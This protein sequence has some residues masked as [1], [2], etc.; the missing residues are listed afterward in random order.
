MYTQAGFNKHCG[1]NKL[2]FDSN[3]WSKSDKVR[4]ATRQDG[5]AA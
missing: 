4:H 2:L 3:D 5:W 1:G